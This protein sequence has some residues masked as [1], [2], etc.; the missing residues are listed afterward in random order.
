MRRPVRRLGD[1]IASAL[2]A[3]QGGSVEG[4]F[5]EFAIDA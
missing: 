4:A 1:L 2:H 3:V 5:L